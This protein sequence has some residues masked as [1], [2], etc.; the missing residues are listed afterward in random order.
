[1]TFLWVLKFFLT[2]VLSTLKNIAWEMRTPLC[3]I[4]KI[5]E[6]SI[7]VGS[8]KLSSQLF[9]VSK[10]IQFLEWHEFGIDP[11]YLSKK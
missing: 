5:A 3:E 9:S 7:I 4:F 11:K 10:T 6:I 1:M 8:D 2:R